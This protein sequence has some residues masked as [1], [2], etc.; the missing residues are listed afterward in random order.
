VLN[1]QHGGLIVVDDEETE[2]LTR[3]EIHSVP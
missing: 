1:Q 3:I 2:A